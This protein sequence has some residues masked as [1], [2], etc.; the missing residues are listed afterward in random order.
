MSP[1]LPQHLPTYP[2]RE[3][4][5]FL[6][7]R[8]RPRLSPECRESCPCPRPARLG[9][10]GAEG[11]KHGLVRASTTCLLLCS[12]SLVTSRH[13]AGPPWYSFGLSATCS[14]IA[15]PPI[16][17][18][19]QYQYRQRCNDLWETPAPCTLALCTHPLRN[20]HASRRAGR[21]R[22]A[23]REDSPLTGVPAGRGEDSNWEE[24]GMQ[25]LANRHVEMTLL[26]T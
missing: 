12:P 24:G 7:A 22:A 8:H 15:V 21:G 26:A 17:H 13:M 6:E 5:G 10:S 4:G 1:R 16:G 2:G 9:V 23:S 18:P 14:F 25:R 3:V 19:M 11:M 20:G